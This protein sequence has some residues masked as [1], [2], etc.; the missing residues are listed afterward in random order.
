MS[1]RWTDRLRL[2]AFSLNES[3]NLAVAGVRS[4]VETGAVAG[5]FTRFWEEGEAVFPNGF[6]P[7]ASLKR[8]ALIILA[9]GDST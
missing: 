2:V 4:I 6:P 3:A 1:I 7:P 9:S 5:V 8:P